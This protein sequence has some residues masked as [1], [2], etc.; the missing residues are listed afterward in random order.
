MWHP[1][2]SRHDVE[3][4]MKVA[5]WFHDGTLRGAHFLFENWVDESGSYVMELKRRSSAH[6]IFQFPDPRRGR[7]EFEIRFIGIDLVNLVGGACGYDGLITS[8]CISFKDG[9]IF[10]AAS[11]G[12]DG[13]VS[14]RS[15]PWVIAEIAEWRIIDG[16]K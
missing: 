8:A 16:K 9:K 4:I 15:F 1:I 3:E 6:L 14:E 12:W 13:D 2:S 5:N 7:V 11:D 10:W